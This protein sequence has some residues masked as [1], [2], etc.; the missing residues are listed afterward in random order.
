M[1]AHILKLRRHRNVLYGF[2]FMLLLFHIVSF[3]TISSQ[4]SYLYVRQ[5]QGFEDYK[6]AF[7][8]LRSEQQFKVQ[9]LT[10]VIGE[11][12]ET[13]ANQ[14]N[15]IERQ[16]DTL[17]ATQQDFSGV[18]ENSMRGVVTVST[19]KSTGTGFVVHSGGYIVTNH[20]IVEDALFIHVSTFDNQ[21][22]TAKVLGSD[23]TIDVSVIKIDGLFSHLP[24]ANSSKTQIGEKVVAI[25]NPL[26]LSFTVTQGIVSAVKR[27]GPNGL[28]TYI[29]TDVTLNRGNSGSPLINTRGEVIGMNNFKISDAEGLGFALESNTVKEAVMRFLPEG[30]TV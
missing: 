22:Y 10:R 9:E 11:Q 29:Q 30:E 27:E 8:E 25:G 2:V 3:I 13:I 19:D 4:L 14:K 16:I 12:Q 17:K 18:I 15:D 5:Q 7:D 26:G 6:S 23:A 20:H 21:L 28:E 1:K 24:L